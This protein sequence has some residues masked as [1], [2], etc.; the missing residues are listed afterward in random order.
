MAVS[1][2]QVLHVLFLLEFERA[3][4]VTRRD[5][6][7]RAGE[8]ET[9]VPPSLDGHRLVPQQGAAD[10]R[11]EAELARRYIPEL[12]GLAEPKAPRDHHVAVP[13]LLASER[14]PTGYHPAARVDSGPLRPPLDLAR[15]TGR[16]RLPFAL[17]MS[18]LGGKGL[19][20]IT[21]TH[22]PAA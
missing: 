5:G 6:T 16:A 9:S 3:G 15:R 10:P 13:H 17:G 20:R 19:D 4:E 1:P 11:G 21:G 18:G 12:V 8:S 7:A 2:F 22:E 14:D